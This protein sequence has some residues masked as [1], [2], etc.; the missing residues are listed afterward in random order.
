MPGESMPYTNIWD[1]IAFDKL[2]HLF[3]F[4][5]LVFLLIIGF[6]KQYSYYNLREHAVKFALVAS[7]LYGIAVEL[8]Q[9]LAPGRTIEIGDMIA[10]LIGCGLGYAFFYLV[11]K[12]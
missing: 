1:E 12:L 8:M 5:V 2:A 9:S 4:A 7:M 10:N 3:V 11:Y 6:T